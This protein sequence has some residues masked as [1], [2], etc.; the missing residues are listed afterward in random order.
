MVMLPDSVSRTALGT[1]Y[2]RA[3]HQIFETEPRVLDDPVAL[4]LIGPNAECR[5]RKKADH[6]QSPIMRALRARTVLRSRYTEDRLYDAVRRGIAQYVILGAGF[7]TF[8]LRQPRWAAQLGIF[9]VDSRATQDEKRSRL[10][11]AGFTV[12]SNTRYSRKLIGRNT[13][14][15]HGTKF[16]MRSMHSSPSL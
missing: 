6:F 2:L 10:T 9:E 16:S 5:I 14:S 7:D 11:A 13:A 8:A 1:A 15:Q 3:A 4:P 12:P